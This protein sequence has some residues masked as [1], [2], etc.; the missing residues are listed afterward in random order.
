V[1]S[2]RNGV[3]VITPFPSTHPLLDHYFVGLFVCVSIEPNEVLKLGSDAASSL[4]GRMSTELRPRG[5]KKT[6]ALD[7]SR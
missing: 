7:R 5:R 4:G 2:W 6:D 3:M 1:R